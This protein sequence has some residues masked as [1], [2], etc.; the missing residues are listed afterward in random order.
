M[1]IIFPSSLIP[2]FSLIH[3]LS[4]FLS[5]LYILSLYF[6]N[7]VIQFFFLYLSVR[8]SSSLI[9]SLC[10]LFITQQKI[11][12]EKEKWRK[13]GKVSNELRNILWHC[14]SQF[15]LLSYALAPVISL[16]CF[17]SKSQASSLFL[18]FSFLYLLFLYFYSLNVTASLS[19]TDTHLLFLY[20]SVW[21]SFSLII[22]LSFL[23]ITK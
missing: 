13:G 5:S 15:L 18:F 1:L 2:V 11:E 7:N 9:L 14:S 4:R 12:I 20:L 22:S 19:N 10:V 21:F 17:F 6:S 16:S 23:F 3:K 8:F